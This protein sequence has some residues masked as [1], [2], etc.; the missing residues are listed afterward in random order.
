MLRA[1]L[2]RAGMQQAMEEKEPGILSAWFLGLPLVPRVGPFAAI[3]PP[4]KTGN[5]ISA[6]VPQAAFCVV[7]KGR[8]FSDQTIYPKFSTKDLKILAGAVPRYAGS[9]L[10]KN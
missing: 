8:K 6:A 1:N 5:R 9:L 7:C 3:F 2:T 4:P 10:R